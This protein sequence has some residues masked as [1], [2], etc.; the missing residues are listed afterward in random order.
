V[1]DDHP[2]VVGG[3]DRG[4]RVGDAV[5]RD[6]RT[7]L[8]GT[9]HGVTL[10]RAS[11]QCPAHQPGQSA[12]IVRRHTREALSRETVGG[13]HVD[14]GQPEQRPRIVAQLPS[15]V[16]TEVRLRASGPAHVDTG[17]EQQPAQLEQRPR[18]HE[19]RQQPGRPARCDLRQGSERVQRDVRRRDDAGGGQGV[20]QGPA[21]TR[22]ESRGAELGEDASLGGRCAQGGHS[23]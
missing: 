15:G 19:R 14:A 13:P 12:R 17:V 3:R 7:D 23:G 4:N 22:P 2:G 1:D 6:L 9:G 16:A 18:G 11:G 5:R 10:S 20:G 21:Q 8:H